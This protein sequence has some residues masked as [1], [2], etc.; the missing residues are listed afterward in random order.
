[1]EATKIMIT[2]H[3]PGKLGGYTE[4]PI[5]TWVYTTLESKVLQ[6][7]DT[8]GEI[9][10]VSGMALG[11]D[12]MLAIMAEIHNIPLIAA[13]PF[14]GQDSKWYPPAQKLYK[15]LT[16]YADSTSDRGGGLV[17]VSPGGYSP[18]KMQV[19]NEW[20]VDHADKIIA[21]W[22]GSSGG[23]ANCVRYALSKG[24]RADITRIDPSNFTYSITNA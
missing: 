16:M 11:A 18:A 2:G 22:D 20:M 4:N 10:L 9:V 7:R 8:Y 19:R 5:T 14:E 17:I 6:L 1:M 13:V 21:V 12:T 23:T 24:R 15:K 3:R